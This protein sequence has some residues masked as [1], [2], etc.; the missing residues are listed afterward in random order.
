[1]LDACIFAGAE[2][3]SA[4]AGRVAHDVAFAVLLG[5]LPVG[6]RDLL[7]GLEDAHPVLVWAHLAGTLQEHM[8]AF[9]EVSAGAMIGRHHQRGIRIVDK[10]VGNRAESFVARG[11][12]VHAPLLVELFD[13]GADIA[14]RQGLHDLFQRRVLLPDDRVEADRLEAGLLQLVI[15]SPRVHRLVLARI[16]DEEDAIVGAEPVEEVVHL[17]RTRQARFID[18]IEARVAVH[19]VGRVDEMTL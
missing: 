5:P 16:P 1:M 8:N 7:P 17:L 14:A 9:V 15:G 2:A 19:R 3:E 11:E 10:G 18:H 6:A 4:A 12:L 13:R